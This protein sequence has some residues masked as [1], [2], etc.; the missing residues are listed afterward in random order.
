MNEIIRFIED[1]NEAFYLFSNY[2]KAE[3][4]ETQSGDIKI[5]IGW[6]YEDFY[7]TI[8]HENGTPYTLN[9]I[10]QS[11]GLIER[12]SFAFDEENTSNEEENTDC[13]GLSFIDDIKARLRDVLFQCTTKDQ[14][15]YLLKSIISASPN[16]ITSNKYRGVYYFAFDIANDEVYTYNEYNTD[17]EIT[18]DYNHDTLGVIDSAKITYFLLSSIESFFRCF[19]RECKAWNIN[20]L[21]IIQN[22]I[23]LQ[24]HIELINRELFSFTDTN[25]EVENIQSDVP[26]KDNRRKNKPKNEFTLRRKIEA[27]K[28][29]IEELGVVFDGTGAKNKADVEK[30]IHFILE[31]GTEDDDIRNTQIPDYFKPSKDT[32]NDQMINDDLSYIARQFNRVGLTELAKKAENGMI[33]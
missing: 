18:V 29:M 26:E 14:R 21:G 4:T 1:A 11:K 31:E 10:F 25:N 23:N 3:R 5:R 20:L 6:E 2:I 27:L 19:E 16:L 32:R 33:Q 12:Y 28:M 13:E 22:V 30:F 9:E 8:K 7:R 15:E 17:K 24:G